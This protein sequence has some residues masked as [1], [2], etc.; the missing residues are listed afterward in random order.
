MAVEASAAAGSRCGT[1]RNQS[2]RVGCSTEGVGCQFSSYL[3]H[4]M[5]LR[6]KKETSAGHG[7]IRRGNTLS[8]GTEPERGKGG[9][10]AGNDVTVQILMTGR[11]TMNCDALAMW[12]R[13]A[14]LVQYFDFLL[15]RKGGRKKGGSFG[16]VGHYSLSGGQGAI[17]NLFNP[18][19][20]PSA[21]ASSFS[22]GRRLQLPVRRSC[23]PHAEV[24]AAPPSLAV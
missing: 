13:P 6:C 3:K 11:A 10:E 18:T 24:F 16:Q 14:M 1:S 2:G 4:S 20:A 17:C 12:W 19:A 21:E 23:R 15:W 8:G 22:A 9:A 5:L 7:A